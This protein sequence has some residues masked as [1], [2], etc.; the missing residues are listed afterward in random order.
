[1]TVG[2]VPVTRKLGVAADT[3]ETAEPVWTVTGPLTVPAATVAVNFPVP[4]L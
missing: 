3:P 4:E 1:M 2:G